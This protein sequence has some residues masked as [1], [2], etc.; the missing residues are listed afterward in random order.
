[1]DRARKE[2]YADHIA[3]TAERHAQHGTCLRLLLT[4]VI[5]KPGI[6]QAIGEMHRLL[7]ARDETDHRAIAG[8]HRALTHP[9][10]ETGIGA[11]AG[12][13]VVEIILLSFREQGVL[14]LA[15]PLSC[16]DDGVEYWLQVVWR[17]RDDRENLRRCHLVLKRLL[18]LA[19]A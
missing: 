14:G 8:R 9:F 17:L 19:L 16:L 1:H 11:D 5:G 4:L 10:N 13:S 15:Q 7:L 2:N 3:S 12:L 6:G 18:E